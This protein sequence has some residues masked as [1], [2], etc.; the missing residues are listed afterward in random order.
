VLEEHIEAM[1]VAKEKADCD[2][3]EMEMRPE[4][5]NRENVRQAEEWEVQ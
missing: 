4:A 1:R 5:Q 3:R 2:R